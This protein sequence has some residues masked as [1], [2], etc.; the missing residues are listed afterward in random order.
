MLKSRNPSAVHPP[1]AK[2][3]HSVEVPPNARWLLQPG[4]S[5]SGPT[6]AFPTASK[7][8]T[9]KSGRTRSPSLPMLGWAPR[10]SYGST[11]I[12]RTRMA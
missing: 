5:A 7:P 11:C 8:N 3:S 2:Y 10:I 6:G 4:K 9:S 1:A 12:R